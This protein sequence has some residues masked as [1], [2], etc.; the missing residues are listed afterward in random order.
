MESPQKSAVFPESTAV[1]AG[2]GVT[3]GGTV[4]SGE[5]V[6]PRAGSALEHAERKTAA[7]SIAVTRVSNKA[8]V[9][10]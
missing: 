6:L 10:C 4:F 8:I 5:A 9:P 2:S 7:G 1:S 3:A